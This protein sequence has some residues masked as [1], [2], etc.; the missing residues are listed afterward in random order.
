[1]TVERN[2]LP[3]TSLNFLSALKSLGLGPTW[4]TFRK[5]LMKPQRQKQR[6]QLSN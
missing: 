6:C 1:M 3:T 4:Y 5:S 2:Q